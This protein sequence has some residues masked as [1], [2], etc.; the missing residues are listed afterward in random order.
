MMMTAL[1]FDDRPPGERFPIAPDVVVVDDEPD[2]AREMANCLSKAGL[3]CVPFFNPWHALRHLASESSPRVVVADV[4]MPELS[5]LELVE[6][7]IAKGRPDRPEIIL[8][9]GNAGLDDARTAMRLGVRRLLCKP[10]DLLELVCEVK[11]AGIEGDLRA[12]RSSSAQP[13]NGERQGD[14]L[15]RIDTLIA[16]SRWRERFFP[17]QML[18]DHCWRMFLELYQS[19]SQGRRVS[20]TSLA[21][22]SGLPMAT[23]VRKIHMMRDLALVN[24][25][26]DVAD[27]RRTF[28]ALSNVGLDKIEQFLA[29]LAADLGRGRAA[30]NGRVA[31]FHSN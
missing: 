1:T 20:L 28:V 27:K 8:V 25:T 30:S 14:K 21:L 29:Q 19:R 15:A 6:R 13:G 24:F 16:Q 26:E 31:T 2:A 22:V 7:L 17:R 12:G 9:S 5:G 23:A 11:N 3:V 10:L 18:S 4:R